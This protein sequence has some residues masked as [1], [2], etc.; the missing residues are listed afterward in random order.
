MSNRQTLSQGRPSVSLA[1]ARR[2]D[3][4][5][6][7]AD[8]IDGDTCL[9]QSTLGGLC[10]DGSA[11]DE[12][13]TARRPCSG[14]ATTMTGWLASRMRRIVL[15]DPNSRLVAGTLEGEW[16]EKLRVLANAREDRE[17]AREQDQF[18]LDKA[19][20]EWLIAMTVDFSKL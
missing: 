13:L 6:S 19:I 5:F 17:H 1:S 18:I 10:T 12:P 15:V 7:A 16:N 14:S 9:E 2:P 3:D 8:R 4:G 11:I 20:R